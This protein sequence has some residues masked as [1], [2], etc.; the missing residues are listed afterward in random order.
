[1]KIKWGRLNPPHLKSGFGTLEI[2]VGLAIISISFFSLMAVSRLSL[3]LVA[4]SAKRVK[5][6]FLLEEGVEA[7]KILRD[8]GWTFNI[9]PLSNSAVYYLDFNNNTWQA[10][11][12]NIYIDGIF[13]RSF[14]IGDVY[15]DANDDI[16]AFGFLDPGTKKVSMAVAW[17]EKS[18]TT[19][20]SISTYITNLF[21]S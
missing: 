4:Q 6:G 8:A 2:I 15:R 21:G 5:A 9:A 20:K 14:T 7:L 11:T 17:K 13:E 18:G 12:T 1:M 16:A 19:T 10:T 3:E